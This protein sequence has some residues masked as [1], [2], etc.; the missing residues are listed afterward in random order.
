[1]TERELL[2]VVERI[3]REVLVQLGYGGAAGAAVGIAPGGAAE[4]PPEECD[5]SGID[6]SACTSCG[7]CVVRRRDMERLIDSG[8][9]RVSARVGI[10][11]VDAKM[12]RLIDHTLLKPETTEKDLDRLCEEA[13]RYGFA[14]V[15][16]NP[17]NVAYCVERLRGSPVKVA[18]VVGFPLGAT[19]TAVKEAETRE[20]IA[21]GA[22]EIDMV[23]NIGRLRA[24]DYAAVYE[25]IRRV[26]EAAGGHVVKVILETALLDEIGKIAGCV[27]AKAAGAHFVKTST[28]FGP[29]GATTED[30]RLMRRVVGPKMGV[31][32]SG[33]I[34]D[35][36]TAEKM[37][38]AGATRI[39]ASASVAIVDPESGSS[40][41]GGGY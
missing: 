25:D 12:S 37:V 22:E 19:T 10:R 26:V 16:V 3:T 6:L 21:Q 17:V 1:M 34:R 8:A 41:R 2:E 27:L 36:A 11:A 5:C 24:G 29:K 35:R 18:A 13:L 15:C 30:V 7:H 14:S 38:E 4:P 31:K 23:I 40:K 28:G 39:G 32:A 9:D 33:G 20:V